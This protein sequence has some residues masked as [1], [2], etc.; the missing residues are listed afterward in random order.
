MEALGEYLKEVRLKLNVSIDKIVEDTHIVKKFIEA[1][2]NEQFSIFPGEA[3]LKGFIRTYS[4]YLG[5]DPEDVIKRYEKIK[6]AESPTPIEQLIPKPSINLKPIFITVG[7]VLLGSLIVFGLINLGISISKNVT[8]EKIDKKKNNK[9]LVENNNTGTTQTTQ[10]IQN[11]K[12]KKITNIYK[13]T[14]KETTYNL[15][16]DEAVEFNIGQNKFTLLL[17][18]LTPTVILVDQS[19]K[20]YY[21]IKSYQQKLDLNHD[22][23]N[24][25]DVIL[26]SWD[27]KVANIK[28]KLYEGDASTTVSTDSS[29]TVST[30]N[31]STVLNIQGDNVESIIKKTEIEDIAFDINVQNETFLRYKADDKQDVESFY[32]AGSIVN[33][34][35][36]K[37]IIIWLSNAGAVNFNFKNYSKILNPGEVGKIEVKLV[38]WVQSSGSEYELQIS[39]L[40]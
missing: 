26:N 34:K 28:I 14:E 2:E 13:M 5:I 18:E 20:E 7:I 6:M 4:E 31:T 19:G 37:S 21:L 24:D 29:N 36:S 39:N 27:E 33:I 12:D 38:K 1:I 32:K 17:K 16:K 9:E 30:N 35:A 3:Y 40:K 25:A 11:G 15:K 10:A 23:S 22:L 8:N